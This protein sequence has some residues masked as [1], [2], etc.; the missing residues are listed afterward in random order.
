MPP[1]CTGNRLRGRALYRGTSS[2]P[3][4]KTSRTRNLSGGCGGGDF[5]PND[6]GHARPDGR[7]PAQDLS[8]SALCPA[9]LYGN[10]LRR[11]DL[12]RRNST[13]GSRT[14][15]IAASPAAAAGAT[16]ARTARTPA[17]RWRYSSRS[18]RPRSVRPG[19]LSRSFDDSDGPGRPGPCISRARTRHARRAVRRRTRASSPAAA[20]RAGVRSRCEAR[21]PPRPRW[22]TPSRHV[23]PLAVRIGESPRDAVGA[24]A[25]ESERVVHGFLFGPDRRALEATQASKQRPH[26]PAPDTQRGE[27]QLRPAPVAHPRDPFLLAREGREQKEEVPIDARPPLPPPPRPLKPSARRRRNWSCRRGPRP[28]DARNPEPFLAPRHP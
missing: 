27:E 6:S 20:P 9:G 19:L 24:E 7:V 14:C 8:G 15:P 10:G 3:G 1:A 4:S 11:R 26:G 17:A 22:R 28:A 13:P 23:E 5:C 12:H 2:T 25:L 16:S 21:L 18:L